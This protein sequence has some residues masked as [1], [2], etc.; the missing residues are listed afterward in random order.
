MHQKHGDSY[1]RNGAGLFE[2]ELNLQVKTMPDGRKLFATGAGLQRQRLWWRLI[3]LLWRTV[4][5]TIFRLTVH[6]ECGSLF[7]FW[8]WRF[9]IQFKS[10]VLTIVIL[11]NRDVGDGCYWWMLMFLSGVSGPD[12]FS[13]DQLCLKMRPKNPIVVCLFK[14]P[15]PENQS[16]ELAPVATR[17][18]LDHGKQAVLECGGLPFPLT[19]VNNVLGFSLSSSV[20]FLRR[21]RD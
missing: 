19:N 16:W 14:N 5:D 20:G 21:S 1:T 13:S 9:G 11:I 2:C 6:R 8:S 4:R 15:D 17:W 7:D 12:L 18:W 10:D 3:M